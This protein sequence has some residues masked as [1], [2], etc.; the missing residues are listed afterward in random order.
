VSISDA[1]IIGAGPSGLYLARELSRVINVTV[2]EEDKALGLPPHCTGLVN[3]DSLKVLNVSP[4]IINTY[5]YV[6]ITDLENHSITFDFK[7]RVI[8]M[9]DRPGLEYNLAD[10]LGSSSLVLGEGVVEINS[11]N[12]RTKSR[13]LPYEL[14]V[15]AEGASGRLG[16]GLIP[17]N[18][19]YVYG[20]QTDTKSY[21]TS[22]L[23]PRGDDEIVVIFDRK[24]SEHFFAW[25]VP[26][27]YHEFRVGIADSSNTWVKFTEL[28]K[29]VGAEYYKPFGG[30]IIIGGSP[31][32]VVAGNVAVIGDAA[33]FVKPMTG[34]GIVMGMLSAKMLSESI[35]EA[36]REGLTISD[37]LLIYDEAYRRYV[38][39]KVKALSAASHILHMMID[40]S[41]DYALNLLGGLGVTVN[42]YDNHIDAIMTAALKRPGAFVKAVIGIVQE[43]SL[44][45]PGRIN[46]LL[47]SLMK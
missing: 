45:E 3:T 25:I 31:E 13:Q 15:I 36:I 7:R 43:L 38:K 44:I 29:M 1:I 12:I 18:P 34:G 19:S 23:M 6:R 42:D 46:E 8:A 5:R 40:K 4:P 39:G 41:L 21:I 10:E 27:D 35:Y 37:A 11:K 22:D 14:T 17:W 26:R 47:K 24:L 20:V 16:R 28:L 30:R 33:G 9:V 2:F 32:H